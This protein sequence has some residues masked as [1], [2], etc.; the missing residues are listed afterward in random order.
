VE[1]SWGKARDVS[2]V[3]LTDAL[4]HRQA[5]ERQVKPIEA[6]ANVWLST[7]DSTHKV[8]KAVDA[9]ILDEAGSMPEWKMPLLARFHPKLLLLVGDHKQLP[10]F[11]HCCGFKPV[12]VLERMADT[13]CNTPTPV[14]I[15]RTQ[16]RMH[17]EICGFVS[18]HFY[19]G[20]LTTAASRFQAPA[21]PAAALPAGMG[22]VSRSEGG[23]IVWCTHSGIE[24]THQHSSTP[25]GPKNV[26]SF[27]KE[28]REEA[29][30][31]CQEI[32][33][34][35]AA[36][37][38]ADAPNAGNKIVI[39][40]LYKAQQ[41][42]LELM[43]AEQK[44]IETPIVMT[45]DSA[46]GSEADIVILSLVRSN[47]TNNIGHARDRQRINVALSRAKHRLI[48]VGNADC[49]QMDKVWRDLSRLAHKE[50]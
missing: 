50:R 46:Q 22:G 17:P 38:T 23:S 39:I 3:A 40:T 1:N 7:V 27:S 20:R 41:R 35:L 43:L 13:L 11:S 30:I 37:H 19:D 15:L 4:L 16:Y 6:S 36:Q 28:N 25:L 32:V 33:P 31:I 34:A 42:L 21:L 14:K 9:V 2:W 49:F 10:P 12:S 26:K 45:V 24:S 44:L 8:R 47:D 48:V 18:R 29:R 5:V